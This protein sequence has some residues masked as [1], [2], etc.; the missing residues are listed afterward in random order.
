MERH[1]S[2]NIN[3]TIVLHQG[4]FC[5][6]LARTVVADD[7]WIIIE[8]AFQ[9]KYSPE[10][11]KALWLLFESHCLKEDGEVLKNYEQFLWSE[12]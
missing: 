9:V 6:C 8:R 11:K 1:R 10:F 2:R 7:Q 4:G 12:V 3:E 5:E